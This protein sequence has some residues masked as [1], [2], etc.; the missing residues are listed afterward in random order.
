[1]KTQ[2]PGL[3]KKPR[4]GVPTSVLI[5][6]WGVLIGREDYLFPNYHSY[7]RKASKFVYGF[8]YSLVPFRRQGSI[9]RHNK[10]I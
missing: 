5:I 7:L 4:K 6:P 8:T 1:M 3:N 2:G 9:N 10:F